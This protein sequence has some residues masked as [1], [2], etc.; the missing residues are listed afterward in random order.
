MPLD[1]RLLLGTG[2]AALAAGPAR[3][4]TPN[5]VKPGPATASPAPQPA[6]PP[7]SRP[8]GAM[9]LA[10]AADAPSSPTGLALSRNGR[11]FLMMP[12]FTGKEP[13]TLGEALPDGTVKPYPDM[14]TNRFDPKRPQ[15]T[16]AHVP[17]GVFDRNDTLWVLDAGL[18]EGK[19]T[20]VPGAAK[21][22]EIDVG[23]NS[24]RRV[25]PLSAG[26]V[27]DSSLNDLRVDVRDG[28]ALAYVTDQGQEGEGAI[29]AVDLNSGQVTR[30]LAGHASTQSQKGIVKFVERRPVMRD[31]GDAPPQSPQGG[32]NGIAIS[33]DGERLYYAPLMGRRLYAVET[34]GLLDPKVSDAEVAASV[35]DLGEKGMT[36][37]LTTDAKDRVYLS[38]QEHN[39]VGRRDPDGTI[40]VIAADD[41]LIWADTFWITPDR[42]L[43]ISSAQVNRRPEFNGGRDLQQKPYA[44][45]RMRIDADPVL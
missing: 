9:E 41:R 17:N 10:L 23:Q 31:T 25:I 36:G 4:E 24:V 7:T 12:R 32:A 2:L 11:V 14:A 37:G 44:I 16:L 19:G 27:P 28:R 35:R 8:V 20:P 15:A 30:R 43:Y 26:V 18:P 38:L 21:I 45:L 1:R 29:L 33:P 13:F 3:A 22:V 6:A 40:A 39:A 34:A 5:P 42:W